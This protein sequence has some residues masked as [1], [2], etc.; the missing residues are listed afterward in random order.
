MPISSQLFPSRIIFFLGAEGSKTAFP[1]FV[2]MQ[3]EIKYH[4]K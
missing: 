3:I 2:G 4:Q 1:D